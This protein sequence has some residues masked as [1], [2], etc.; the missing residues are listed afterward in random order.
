MGWL[1]ELMAESST[2]F[3]SYDSL[4]EAALAS[5]TWPADY[6][7]QSRSL[8]AIFSKLDRG[9]ELEWLLERPAVQ[10][11]LAE[12]LGSSLP[13]F[14]TA[15]RAPLVDSDEGRRLRLRDLRL[16]RALDLAAD[17]L[18][19]GVPAAVCQP[20]AWRGGLWWHAP[21]GAGRSLVGRWLLARGLAEFLRAPSWSEAHPRIGSRGPVFVEIEGSHPEVVPA[22][23]DGVCVAASWLPQGELA[24]W[25]VV[26]SPA[27]HDYLEA[28]VLWVGSRLPSG[29]EFDAGAVL[30]WLKTEPFE[31]GAI[32]TLGMVIGLCG[33]AAEWGLDRV[34]D[35]SLAEL[36]RDYF[37]VTLSRAAKSG[38]ED[39][40]WVRRLGFD[41]MTS[42][43]R[44]IL[45]ESNEGWGSP[46]TLEAWLD[47]VPAEHQRGADLEWMKLS[48]ALTKSPLRNADL[49]RAA[50]RVPP[51]AYRI[52]RTLQSVGILEGVQP[53]ERLR[54]EPHWFS[55]A[56]ASEAL[57]RLVHLSPFE[58]GEGLIRPSSAPAVARSLYLRVGAGD[59]GAIEEVLDLPSDDNPAHVAALEAVFVTTG[60]SLLGG[61]ELP[62]DLLEALW[63][64]QIRLSIDLPDG[65]VRRRIEYPALAE[66]LLAP[67]TWLLAALAIG[68]QLPESRGLCHPLLRPWVLA[69]AP[70][71]LR[72]AYD[73]IRAALLLRRGHDW[74][75]AAFALVDR[76]RGAIGSVEQAG[77][78]AHA[79]E[80]PGIF[81]D[82]VEHGVP[83]WE[84]WR[85]LTEDELS[86]AALEWL[87]GARAL[88]WSRTASAIL[89]AWQA[90]GYPADQPLLGA[91]G[92]KNIWRHATSS[93]L[94]DWFARASPEARRSA[95]DL[96]EDEQWLALEEPLSGVESSDDPVLWAKMPSLLAERLLSIARLSV[97]GAS[98]RTLWTRDPEVVLR[99]LEGRLSE[100]SADE[101]AGVLDAAPP[102]HT[103]SVVAA[104]QRGVDP[105]S[106]PAA[107]LDPIRS[108]LHARVATRGVGWREAYALLAPIERALGPLRSAAW[109]SPRDSGRRR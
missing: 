19:P 21:T 82:E 4:A 33:L 87:G 59:Y 96:L 8:A 20:S 90:A 29:A 104:L 25:T 88:P 31:A 102:E 107:R 65:T 108:W 54:L 16:A 18:C 68:E 17:T 52:I 57:A 99:V 9:I 50:R 93:W 105:A 72:G 49:E 41:V 106:S 56:V 77:G 71:S 12:L 24:A 84:T 100:S 66:P 2:P 109:T 67:G 30:Q 28:L 48:L 78:R 70:A 58:W 10:H 103:A 6:R 43:G 27:P 91:T 64:E 15:A 73:A 86:L 32:D 55:R 101:L 14:R 61:A 53:N 95:Y 98:M 45:T 40:N 75:P 11:I 22:Q 80:L 62:S 76:L 39:A 7:P 44:S 23:R 46:R 38:N 81:L 35:K 3:R 97:S 60:L 37:S 13:D 51:G 5:P 36:A 94:A 83:A 69:A 89:T 34:R 63:D 47:L 1:R 92:T 79:L 74:R 42:I 85:A 26:E